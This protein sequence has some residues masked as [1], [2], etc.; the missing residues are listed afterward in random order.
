M[1]IYGHRTPK[2]KK[3]GKERGKNLDTMALMNVCMVYPRDRLTLAKFTSRILINQRYSSTCNTFHFRKPQTPSPLGNITVYH[4][5]VFSSQIKLLWQTS[6][7][8]D[9]IFSRPNCP[10]MGKRYEFSRVLS[11]LF[12]LPIWLHLV[13]YKEYFLKIFKYAWK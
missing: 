11:V 12:S 3:K 10:G 6:N 13:G 9:S 1:A 7:T 5:D 8:P 2:G 4:A